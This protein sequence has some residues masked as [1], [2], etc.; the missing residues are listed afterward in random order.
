LQANKLTPDWS[1]LSGA[2][3]FFSTVL[4]IAVGVELFSILDLLLF[5]WFRWVWDLTCD[6]WAENAKNNLG[7][8]EHR[9]FLNVTDDAAVA[10]RS[11]KMRSPYPPLIA[12]SPERLH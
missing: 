10:S 6:F 3:F 4:S 1:C 7:R 8:P 11:L 12:F 2:N 9:S 5:V